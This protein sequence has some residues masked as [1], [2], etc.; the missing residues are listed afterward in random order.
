MLHIFNVLLNLVS[1]NYVT[2]F[3]ML[4]K[5]LILKVVDYIKS[6]KNVVGHT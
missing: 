5:Q 2:H 3:K 4:L 6:T 1:L